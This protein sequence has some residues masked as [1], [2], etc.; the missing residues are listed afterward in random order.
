MLSAI[1][2]LAQNFC[3]HDWEY[4]PVPGSA[5]VSQTVLTSRW[6]HDLGT[7]HPGLPCCS[8]VV[9]SIGRKDE[10]TREELK[11]RRTTTTDMLWST[12]ADS[13]D[14]PQAWRCLGIIPGVLIQLVAC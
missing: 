4:F 1:F 3:F 10:Q 8:H 6:V 11:N 12:P 7:D 14:I 13:L 2:S 5:S 9:V